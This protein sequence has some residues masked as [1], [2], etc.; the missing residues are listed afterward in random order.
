MKT[1]KKI[2]AILITSMLLLSN[3]VFAREYAQRFWDVSKDHWAFEYIADLTERKVIRGYEDGSFRPERTVTRAEWAKMMVDAA[4]VNSSD[5]KVYWEDLKDHWANN[6]VNAASKYLT[7]Y[8]DNYYR[9]DQAVTR[10]DVA[11]A[12]V[13]IK[14]YDIS[15]VDFAYLNSF[16]DVSSIS[17]YAKAYV[18]VGV[19]QNLI[20][21]FSDK[22]FRGQDTLTRA[23]AAT[24]MYRAF[25]QGN[26]DKITE[27]P[28]VPV[29]SSYEDEYK[30]QAEPSKATPKPTKRPE[31]VEKATPKP[32]PEPAP[33]PEPEEVKPHFE[34]TTLIDKRDIEKLIDG[35]ISTSIYTAPYKDGIVLSVNSYILTLDSEGECN[36]VYDFS[37]IKVGDI[38]SNSAFEIYGVAYDSSEDRILVS[39]HGDDNVIYELKNGECNMLSEGMELFPQGR[40]FV[41]NNGDIYACATYVKT[42]PGDWRILKIIDDYKTSEKASDNATS[43]YDAG[44]YVVYT[45]DGYYPRKFVKKY[46]FSGTDETLFYMDCDIMGIYKESIAVVGKGTDIGVVN[47]K[48]ENS[49]EKYSI[50][51]R[52]SKTINFKNPF[53]AIVNVIDEKG[54]FIFYDYTYKSFRLA[55]FVE[56]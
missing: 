8:S 3:N 49:S 53:T 13:K 41:F 46:D 47:L 20:A 9:P 33:T 12:L 48:N 45:C 21:G 35:K 11:V 36:I 55:T 34:V 23:E 32:T 10:E 25:K 14:G 6:Y 19:Q 16:T 39:G 42:Q 29:S 37:D 30:D 15:D 26:A 24:L 1:T 27:S 7:G 2:I 28:T 5:N 40:F 4:G 31:T 50:K 17:N 54:T 56:E 43:M 18:A 38:L 52:D 22:T 44:E 51:V